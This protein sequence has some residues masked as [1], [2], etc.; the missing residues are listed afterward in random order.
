MKNVVILKPKAP[1]VV[2]FAYAGTEDLANL[3]AF[4]GKNPTVSVQNGNPVYTFRRHAVS[5][6][7][8]VFRNE[9]G[10]VTKVMKGSDVSKVYDVLQ[11]HDF[12]FKKHSNEV[13]P[14]EVKK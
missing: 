2:A 1:E 13:K 3:I 11:E 10:D 12:D 9:Y 5:V 8:V 6:G 4:V 7:D 14:K